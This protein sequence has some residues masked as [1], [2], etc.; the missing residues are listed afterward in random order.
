MSGRI[1]IIDSLAVNRIIL[2]VK[3]SAWYYDVVQAETAEQ[4]LKVLQTEKIDLIVVSTSL[5]DMSTSG[6][7]TCLQKELKA[8]PVP[9]VVVI[10]KTPDQAQKNRA[11]LRGAQAV[12]TRPV[13]EVLLLAHIRSLL[14]NRDAETDLGFQASSTGE[15]EFS[16]AAANFSH[17]PRIAVMSDCDIPSLKQPL[18]TLDGVQI[19]YT[20][21]TLLR[22]ASENTDVYV[23][24]EDPKTA[25]IGL[26]MLAELRSR[27]VSRH[28]AILY[29]A[30]NG[31]KNAAVHALDLGAS[32][33]VIGPTDIK[34]ISIRI[35][36]LVQRKM[37]H[38]S[39][40]AKMKT[41]LEAAMT[42]PL[43]GLYNRRHA[44]PYLNRTLK[45]SVAAKSPVSVLLI[46]ID[47]F[48][49]VNDKYG[50]ANGDRALV[51]VATR[52]REQ[53]SPHEMVARIGGEEFV[54]ILPKTGMKRAI[55]VAEKIRN[56]MN[57]LPVQL[58]EA[59]AF[60]SLSI[61]VATNVTNYAATA[62][63]ILED[64]DTALYAAK[65]NGRN[66][67]VHSKSQSCIQFRSPFLPRDRNS[68]SSAASRSA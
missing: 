42:D 18:E 47:Y 55:R 11:L 45:T 4:A 7:L 64:A 37:R 54:V 20:S 38:D 19:V 9:P 14:R 28:A 59:T 5:T 23:L 49:K 41:E 44:M 68:K 57:R 36:A 2:R 58:S 48:K 65:T 31:Q 25:G 13:D 51:E 39:L 46:D 30:S 6:F 62:S 26:S 3:L 63:T 40:R 34:E 56:T 60:L 43:T 67:V 27:T 22:Q 53:L 15:F 29:V 52:L 16:E 61:G 35:D 24:F 21:D 66:K 12:L 8:I 32:D 17:Q 10:Q 33:I 50:H 1:L